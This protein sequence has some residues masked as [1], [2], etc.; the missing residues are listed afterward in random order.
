MMRHKLIVSESVITEDIRD[1][2]QYGKE[3]SSS[4]RMSYSLFF[5][6]THIFNEKD[7]LVHDDRLDALAIGCAYLVD[8]VDVDVEREIKQ[9][10]DAEIEAI[11]NREGRYSINDMYE[12]DRNP[13]K[14]DGYGNSILNMM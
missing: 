5:Q 6:M 10:A 4:T 1:A 3:G 13:S 2:E 14:N 9:M 8:S 7:S 12:I 11:L